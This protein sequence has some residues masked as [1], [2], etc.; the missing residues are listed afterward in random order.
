MSRDSP[1]PPVRPE[2][3]YNFTIDKG[4]C[5]DGIKPAERPLT[6][7]GS[8]EAAPADYNEY[9][10]DQVRYRDYVLDTR[11]APRPA[12]QWLAQARPTRVIGGGFWSPDQAFQASLGRSFDVV[13]HFHQ[14]KAAHLLP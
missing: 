5:P 10:L 9:V 13:I 12:K 2:P 1:R 14:V 8:V 7:K 4:D 11:T 6:C 3:G